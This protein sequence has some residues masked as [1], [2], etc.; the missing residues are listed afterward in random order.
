MQELPAHAGLAGLA[1]QV[2]AILPVPAF[3]FTRRV[4][5]DRVSILHVYGQGMGEWIVANADV[6]RVV[7]PAPGAVRHAEMNALVIDPAGALE[8]FLFDH[9]VTRVTSIAVDGC[10]RDTRFWIAMVGD[11]RLSPPQLDQFTKLAASSAAVYDTPPEDELTRLRRLELAAGTLPTLLEVLDLREVFDRV[12]T[13]AQPALAHDLLTAILFSEDL[14]TFSIFARSDKGTSVSPTLPN[15]YA[16]AAIRSYTWAIVSDHLAHPLEINSPGTRMGARS[17]MRVPIR[18]GER[19]IGGLGFASF[20]TN[21]YTTADVL[22]ARRIAAQLA[23]GISHYQLAE[24]G[25]RT[26]ALRERTKNLELLDQLLSAVSDGD[27]VARVFERVSKA[28]ANVLRHDAAALTVRLPD[29]N[30]VRLYASSGFPENQPQT[31]EIPDDIRRNPKWSDEI[32][33]DLA[34]R[35]EQRYVDLVTMGF[36]SMLRVPILKDGE[37]AAALIFV[38]KEK[39]AFRPDDIPIAK[40]IAERLTITLAVDREV[41]AARRADEAT[42]RAARL[43]ARVRALTDELN[44]KSGFRR[45]IGE[46]KQWRHVLTQATQVAAT[47]TTVLLLGESGT[48]KEVVARFLHRG[49]P[50]SGGPFVAINCAALPEQ[51]L[52]AELFGYERGAFTG[53]MQS[54][55]GQLELAS[56][57]TLFLDEVAEMSPASQAKF[58]RVLQEREFQRLGGTRVLRTDARIVAATNRDLPRDI[59]NG[60]FREDLYYRLNVFAIKLPPLRERRDDVMHLS[61]DFLTEIGKGLGRPPSGISR[62]AKQMLTGYHWP[63]NVRELRNVLERAAILSDGGLITGD[64]LAL[65][66]APAAARAVAPVAVTVPDP[67]PAAT[68]TDASGGDLNSM[69]RTMIEQA[70]QNAKFN[71]S[72]AAKALGLTRHQLYIRMRKHGFD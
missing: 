67:T 70:L 48:G 45:V 71:K 55:P 51:L 57:G 34:T 69:E 18:Y 38:S 30:N 5:A 36:H 44:A 21:S 52:E 26:A 11:Q 19:V 39:A 43:E 61:E 49:S 14:S 41:A 47:Q 27:D 63:G 32:I 23:V 28:V 7:D 37:F 29:G 3:G 24:E 16:P 4:D 64:H 72:K 8:R 60:K 17:S 33:D 20:R 50:R 2:K 9:A 53:A 12:S 25:R 66:P 40:R 6:P 42:E 68:A 15:A 22:A 65:A 31:I 58:L 35:R 13:A 56:G 62:D 59:A 46:S 1:D 54:K 10:A